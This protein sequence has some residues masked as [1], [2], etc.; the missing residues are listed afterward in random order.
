[1]S[2]NSDTLAHSDPSP[3]LKEGHQKSGTLQDTSTSYETTVLNNAPAT[4]RKP[5][6]H[7][8]SKPKKQASKQAT[9]K[10][11]PKKSLQ[12]TSP[13]LIRTE[14]L[15]EDGEVVDGEGQWE[16]TYRGMP[17]WLSSLLIHLSLILI[18]ALLSVNNGGKQIV[19]LLA[20]TTDQVEIEPYDTFE[21]AL[22]PEEI[23][24][25]SEELESP[26]SKLTET[27]ELAPVLDEAL[28]SASLDAEMEQNLFEKISSTGLDSSD[29]P[30][31]SDQ[32]K[33]EFFG[34]NGEGSDFVFIIDCSD[35][36]NRYGRW[37]Q[38]VAELKR[39][40]NDLKPQ[41]RFLILLYNSGYTAMN[42]EIK[43]VKSTDRQRKKAV[44]WLSSNFPNSWTYCAEALG[45][46]LKLKP[47]AVFLLSDG[48]FND[49]NEVFGVLDRF[50]SKRKL[51]KS[52]MQQ[53]PVHTVALG[54][55]MG[56]FTM[57]RI[58]QENN[59]IFK[60]IE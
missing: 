28:L 38:A 11:T 12:K 55:H 49:R 39:S 5:A 4:K 24:T 59:G 51:K 2:K 34:I 15:N 52:G 47:S 18:L 16:D 42:N 31:N 48:E 60:L 33:A 26:E 9:P 32:G 21:L 1:M 3:V 6:P 25:V 56:R 17:S 37:N 44:R 14:S 29:L 22:Q 43:L 46:A 58:A 50:N 45:E 41:Q 7:I 57:E 20:G 8:V 23:Q 40:I 27:S 35:S 53:I 36:M 19:D 13:F 10:R 54:S 30:R